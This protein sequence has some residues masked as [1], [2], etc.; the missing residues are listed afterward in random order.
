MYM[1]VCGVLY[2]II[3]GQQLPRPKHKNVQDV[4]DKSAP[5]PY[6]EVSL[7]LPDWTHSPLLPPAIPTLPTIPLPIPG[8]I[9]REAPPPA[10][11][12]LVVRTVSVRTRTIK[13]NDFNPVWNEDLCIPFDHIGGPEMQELI[14]VNVKICQEGK[15]DPIAQYCVPL[16]CLEQGMCV[17]VGEEC[18]QKSQTDE[19]RFFFFGRF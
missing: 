6:V 15:E 16:G 1:C 19:S 11:P 17:C 18:L 9:A 13:N 10:E 12:S 14:F 2:Q 7:H 8:V 4:V 5:D 3:S